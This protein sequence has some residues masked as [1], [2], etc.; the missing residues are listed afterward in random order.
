MPQLD[1]LR[2]FAVLLVL[3]E[4]WVPS[5]AKKI[6]FID[7]G[8]GVIFFFVLSGYL[9]TEIL[10]ASKFKL[11]E[12]SNGKAH[13]VKQF[14]I[15][16]ALRI[17]PA[18]YAFLFVIY[19][20]PSIGDKIKDDYTWY[21]L[22]LNNFSIYLNQDWGV[23]GH[24]WSLA[25]EEQF[26]LFWPWVI[27]FTPSK[28][29]LKVILLFIGIG[30]CSRELYFI[31][32]NK[33][34]LAGYGPVITLLRLDAFGLGAL[35]A[36]QNTIGIVDTQKAKTWIAYAFCFLMATWVSIVVLKME[37]LKWYV[38]DIIIGLLALCIIHKAS[39]GF[40]GVFKKLLEHPLLIYFGRISY[41]LYLFHY[42]IP[43]LY[44]LF[45]NPYLPS[46][47]LIIRLTI[48]FVILLAL[49]ITSWHLFELP[50]NNLK[51]HFHYTT[52]KKIKLNEVTEQP[53]LL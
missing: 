42:I 27:L 12:S 30:F 52:S 4:H 51:R 2:F 11:S 15:R 19:F 7:G 18:Y 41:G 28:H 40:N 34:D 39:F 53:A 26:Y 17:F 9:I 46:F 47:S 10:I 5:F 44:K 43:D 24:T 48:Y 6:V 22:Y 45:L 23:I 49:A 16:R 33:L 20:L 50:I 35:L 21:L 29:L 32:N 1:T 25:V 13:V 31:T 38:T 36:Y 3:G 8:T 37:D 14:T